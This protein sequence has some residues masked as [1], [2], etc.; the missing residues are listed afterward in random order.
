MTDDTEG[1]ITSGLWALC[2]E[3]AARATLSTGAHARMIADARRRLI[4]HLNKALA[5]VPDKD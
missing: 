5:S 4:E 3:N 1:L 2:L